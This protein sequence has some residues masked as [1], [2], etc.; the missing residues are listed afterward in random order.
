MHRSRTTRDAFT[1]I[2]ILVVVIII[3]ILAALLLPAVSGA[4]RRAQEARISVEINALANAMEDLKIKFGAYPADFEEFDRNRVA[5][6]W[7]WG[8]YQQTNTGRFLRKQFPKMQAQ[9]IK[10][11]LQAGPAMDNAEVLVLWLKGL[12]TNP[13]APFTGPK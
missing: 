8:E 4:I 9:D 7:T 3:T 6:A 2:E 10:F 1:L 13:K 12:S 5:R 11:L